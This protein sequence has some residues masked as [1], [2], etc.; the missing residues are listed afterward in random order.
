MPR[1]VRKPLSFRAAAISRRLRWRARRARTVG[2]YGLFVGVGLDV[3]LVRRQPE[4]VVDVAHA[5]PAAS[6]VLEHVAGTLP[7]CFP[8]P[9][10]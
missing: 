2:Q 4:T 9:L 5:L 10:G 6:F 3:L 1:R 8:L 7:D